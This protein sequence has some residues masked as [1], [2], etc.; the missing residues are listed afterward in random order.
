MNFRSPREEV[1][2]KRGRLKEG[3]GRVLN[4]GLLLW[5]GG[6]LIST[7]LK[8]WGGAFI[9][10]GEPIR[11]FTL[12]SVFQQGSSH[13][14]HY[15]PAP[16][17]F[18]RWHTEATA[19]HALG[20]NTRLSLQLF[21]LPA[22]RPSVVAIVKQKLDENSTRAKRSHPLRNRVVCWER[23]ERCS[24]TG[25]DFQHHKRIHRS[26]F[27]RAPWVFGENKFSVPSGASDSCI[28]RSGGIAE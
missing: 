28:F 26:G 3:T 27:F 23:C 16:I 15:S 10:E 21:V 1:Y 7:N 2:I 13:S 20:N 8:S 5:G 19:L 17:A 4:K 25:P 12:F 24:S 6:S 18:L 22:Q 9:W 11:S 14:H